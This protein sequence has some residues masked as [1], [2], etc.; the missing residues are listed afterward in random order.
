MF[1]VSNWSLQHILHPYTKFLPHVYRFCSNV[2]NIEN[3]NKQI[4][5]HT[6]IYENKM[7][8][9]SI[10]FIITLMPSDQCVHCTCSYYIH[11]KDKDMYAFLILSITPN[12]VIKTSL[13]YFHCLLLFNKQRLLHTTT[14][15]TDTTTNSSGNSIINYWK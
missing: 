11:S 8:H 5:R 3:K 12:I 4:N 7:G 2:K 15:A 14:A 1:E 10:L 6:H 13:I 9:V